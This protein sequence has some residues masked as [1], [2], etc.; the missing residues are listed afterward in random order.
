[1]EKT[2]AKQHHPPDLVAGVPQE[3]TGQLR[4]VVVGGVA[5][6]H[7]FSALKHPNFR[8]FFIGQ[9]VSLIGTWMQTTA[10]G[11]L[12][13][14][15]TGSKALLGTVAAAGSLPLLLLSPWGG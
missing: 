2:I 10:Q 1:M 15:L 5:W 14:E 12:V 4:P 3:V 7:T 6:R 8:L 13:Y 9:L 11:W